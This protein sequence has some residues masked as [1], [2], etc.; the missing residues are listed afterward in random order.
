MRTM[1]SFACALMVLANAAPASAAP[2][3]TLGMS[4]ISAM[5]NANGSIAAG[6]G[7]LN[8][9]KL[10]TGFYNVTFNRTLSGCTFVGSISTT[11]DTVPTGTL[12][13]M[14]EPSDLRILN[15]ATFSDFKTSADRDFGV[16]VF[17]VR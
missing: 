6:A 11:I 16:M 7:V 4:V 17:C 14:R 8:S 13:M 5:I 9:A 1:M 2:D 12:I 10:T 3:G 15:V